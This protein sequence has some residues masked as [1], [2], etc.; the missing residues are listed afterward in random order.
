MAFGFGDLAIR[1]CDAG[2]S[3]LEWVKEGKKKR[4]GHEVRLGHP[5]EKRGCG[6]E[7]RGR[8]TPWVL[9]RWDKAGCCFEMDESGSCLKS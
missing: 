3:R 9:W 4:R 7:K 2:R 5:L 1:Q 6:G 8:Q